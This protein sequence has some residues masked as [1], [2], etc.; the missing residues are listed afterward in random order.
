V[1][2]DGTVSCHVLI[3]EDGGQ[4]EEQRRCARIHGIGRAMLPLA[5]ERVS[6]RWAA[7]AA[8]R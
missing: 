1:V 8:R 7:A 2:E 5:I 6:K 4:E 3:D